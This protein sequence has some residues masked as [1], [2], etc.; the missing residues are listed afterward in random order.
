MKICPDDEPETAQRQQAEIAIA[1]TTAA[2]VEVGKVSDN[3]DISFVSSLLSFSLLM[4]ED[5]W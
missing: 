5:N 4:L 3:E 1:V 2:V